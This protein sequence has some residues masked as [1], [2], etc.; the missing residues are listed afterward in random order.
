MND[1]KYLIIS[2]LG[3]L[4]PGTPKA[5]AVVVKYLDRVIDQAKSVHDQEASKEKDRKEHTLLGSLIAQNV[6]ESVSSLC[7]NFLLEF[8]ESAT[9]VLLLANQRFYDGNFNWW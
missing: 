2:K 7:Y 3:A 1:L 8:V 5:S 4:L 6:S 9:K